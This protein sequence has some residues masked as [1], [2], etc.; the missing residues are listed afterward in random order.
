MSSTTF[1][2]SS[3]LPTTPMIAPWSRSDASNAVRT[4]SS[5]TS[6]EPVR[7]ATPAISDSSGSDFQRPPRRIRTGVPSVEHPHRLVGTQEHADATEGT[8]RRGDER[9]VGTER[10][11]EGRQRVGRLLV[12]AQPAARHLAEHRALGR[13]HDRRRHPVE[14]EGRPLQR[15]DLARV[16][17]AER[18]PFGLLRGDHHAVGRGAALDARGGELVDVGEHVGEM[19]RRPRPIEPPARLLG[20]LL[21]HHLGHDHVVERGHDRRIGPGLR[22]GLRGHP[23][24]GSNRSVRELDELGGQLGRLTRIELDRL[25]SQPQ[26]QPRLPAQRP[27]VQRRPRALRLVVGDDRFEGAGRVGGA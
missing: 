24:D 14:E 16:L 18:L 26:A 15:P 8:G 19:P 5:A 11:L 9:A 25:R 12:A 6:A 2:T 1:P 22:Q 17:H 20:E 4:T 13:Q 7:S 3:P 23:L 27:L 10:L 21:G